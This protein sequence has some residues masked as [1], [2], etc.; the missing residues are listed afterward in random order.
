MVGQMLSVVLA[1][2]VATAACSAGNKS[3]KYSKYK[4]PDSSSSKTG[5]SSDSSKPAARYNPVAERIKFFAAAGK[6]SELSDKEFNSDRTK[7]NG[8]VRKTDSWSAMLKYDKDRNKTI[9]WFEAD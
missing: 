9:D 7:G 6:D 8:F 4:R 1:L 3:R 5:T 2:C